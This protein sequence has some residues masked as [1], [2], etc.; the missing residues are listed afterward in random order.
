MRSRTAC[1]AFF[2]AACGTNDGSRPQTAGVEEL[3]IAVQPL[4]AVPKDVLDSVQAA[5]TREHGATAS[6]IPRRD[7]PI[8]AFTNVRAPRYR[9]DSL[10]AWLREIKPDSADL[11]IGITGQDISITKV[12]ST[13]AVK[14]PAWKYRDFGIFGLGYMGGPSCVVSTYRLGDGNSAQF[15]DRLKKIAV[16]EVGHNRSLPHCPDPKC[17]MRSAKERMSSVDEAGPGLCEACAGRIRS[18]Q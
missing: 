5:I 18:S 3:V 14:E 9:A 10:I 13:G 7:L 15:F 16:H 1:I 6:L 4:G 12:D 11:I 8:N 2:L 17:V